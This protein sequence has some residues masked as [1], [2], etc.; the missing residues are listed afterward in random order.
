RPLPSA[1]ACLTRRSRQLVAGM[2]VLLQSFLSPVFIKDQFFQRKSREPARAFQF[3]TRRKFRYVADAKVSHGDDVRGNPQYLTKLDRVDNTHPTH[4]Y[5]LGPCREPEV[6]HGATCAVNV[7]F[8]NSVASQ[9]VR[10][11]ARWVT[12]EADVERGLQYPLQFQTRVNR[13]L[14]AFKYLTGRLV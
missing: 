13:P 14:L 7:G 2:S 10:P 6:L 9:D 12:G 5:S 3:R 4:A 1:D 11:I 8:R